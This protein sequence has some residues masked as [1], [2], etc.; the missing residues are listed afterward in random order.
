MKT[1]LLKLYITGNNSRSQQAIYNL[2]R[3]CEK[4]LKNEYTLEIID[5]L[6]K[7]QLAEDEKVFA[8]P[9]LEKQLP[10]PI[11]RIIGDLSNTDRVLFGLDIVK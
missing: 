11:R 8:T 7:P 6:E 2:K 9:T 10:P 1:I 3:I 4:E 5:I